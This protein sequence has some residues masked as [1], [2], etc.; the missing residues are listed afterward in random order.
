MRGPL[1]SRSAGRVLL[2]ACLAMGG[3]L[4]P[5]AGP[6]LAVEGRFKG[7]VPAG[8]RQ[9]SIAPL[10]PG[11][12]PVECQQRAVQPALPAERLAELMHEPVTLAK[13]RLPIGVGRVFDP[14]ILVNR[15]MVPAEA[16]TV[17]PNGWR[18]YSVEVASP[19]ALGL[20]LHLEAL[21]L[22]KG[23]RLLIYDS[24]NPARVTAPISAERVSAQREL[25]AQTV[26]AEKVVLECQVP[27]KADT[28]AVS[29]AVTGLS[30]LYRLPAMVAKDLYD[31]GPC[32]NDVTCYP[33]W[34]QAAAAVAQLM[35]VDTGITYLCTGCLLNSGNTNVAADYF[36]TAHHCIPDQAVA[37]TLEWFWF[38]QTST[39]HGTPPY[40]YDVPH[41]GGGADWLA[42]SSL[43]D[44][45]F[46]Q[47]REAPP[48]GV[49]YLGWS[50][51]LPMASDTLACIHHPAGDYKRISFC[52][53]AIPDPSFWWVQWFSGVVEPG[54]SGSPLL[55]PRHQIIGQLWGGSSS[56]D[57]PSG[58]DKFGRFDVTYHA[59]QRWLDPIYALRGT[60][61]GLFQPSNGFAPQAMGAFTLTLAAS[62]AFSGRLQAGPAHYPLR[63][64]FNPAGDVQLLA[65]AGRSNT[66]T[67]RLHLD[68]T[69]GTE[70][71]TGTVEGG[72]WTAGV[73]ADRGV[74]AVPPQ[75]GRYTMVFP[76]KAGS[77]T[78]PG[79]DSYATV[80]VS[81]TGHVQLSGLLADGTR[82]SQG[83]VVSK[84]GQWPLYVPLSG[85]GGFVQCWASFTNLAEADLAGELAW[86]KPASTAKYYPGG[87][88]FQTPLSGS[89]YT[90]PAAGQAMLSFTNAALVLTGGSPDQS[91]TK[92][93]TLSPKSQVSIPADK[94]RLTFTPATGLFRGS[95]PD[96]NTLKPIA[97]SGV[98]LP[99]QNR[100]SGSFLGGGLSGRAVLEPAP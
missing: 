47:L 59:I 79:G 85:S 21:A 37:D 91:L 55:N 86:V 74:S 62:G 5:W 88:S 93:F 98:V 18:I 19:G 29:F 61:R 20:R 77:A 3:L 17:L 53:E 95:V 73:L 76:G 36:L 16:W 56:C 6:V 44:F 87:F 94:F 52:N 45:A 7:P 26:F 65:H 51:T 4:G 60:Y 15:D 83:S 22:P 32:H 14:A 57:N 13:G 10:G 24:A 1:L 64:K 46:L 9:E 82:F 48:A 25:W 54:S 49:Y 68:I 69:N 100:G 23:A 80:S 99:N 12:G 90:H 11:L 78:E 89:L 41:T 34:A 81:K 38:Y 92:D 40:P 42:G 96:L 71:I 35:F 43:S 84:Y 58:L 8:G 97:F 70:R 75:A 39:C 2:V 50:R 67:L 33:E 28:V 30:H 31:A 72:G 66:V 63:G 27:P